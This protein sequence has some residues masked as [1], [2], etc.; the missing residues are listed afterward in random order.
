MLRLGT[1][2]SLCEFQP[3][4]LTVPRQHSEAILRDHLF[5]AL[6]NSLAPGQPALEDEVTHF[7]FD[8]AAGEGACTK[9]GSLSYSL[10]SGVSISHKSDILILHPPDMYVS[11]ELKFLSAVTDQFKTRSYDMIHLK[12]SHRTRLVGIMVYVHQ[13]GVGL[14]LDRAQTICYSFDYFVGLKA[15]DLAS[16]GFWV[17]VIDAVHS[18]L[19]DLGR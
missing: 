18:G 10:P 15:K 12:S 14:S 8:S 16:E 2:G 3:G 6:H 9:E 5:E 13:P 17:P 7:V 1:D 19:D 11:V 4:G